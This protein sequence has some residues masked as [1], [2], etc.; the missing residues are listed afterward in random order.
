MSA[1]L[2]HNALRGSGPGHSLEGSSDTPI[3]DRGNTSLIVA[4]AVAANS[5]TSDAGHAQDRNVD[6]LR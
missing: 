5:P 4:V 2:G 6:A 3:V 1:P